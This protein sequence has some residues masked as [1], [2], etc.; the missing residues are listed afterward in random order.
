[1]GKRAILNGNFSQSYFTY[2]DHHFVVFVH[3]KKFYFDIQ[4]IISALDLK[5]SAW[6]EKY[7]QYSQNIKFCMWHKNEFGG[8]ILRELI[9][10][11]TVYE[12]VLSSNSDISKKF[13]K[14]VA[15][16]LTE[17]REEGELEI[18]NTEIKKKKKKEINMD[19]EKNNML[20]K[21]KQPKFMQYDNLEDQLR[22]Q[23][24]VNRGSSINVIDYINLPV[25]Y[26]FIMPFERDHNYVIVKIGYSAD[27]T[28]RINSL[29]SEFGSMFYL[30]GLKKITSEK[31]EKEFHELLKGYYPDNIEEME[32]K[33]KD[34]IELYKLSD[35]ILSEFENIREV[36][37][38]NDYEPTIEDYEITGN[39]KNQI[40]LFEQKL[41]NYE[42]K[43]LDSL[44]KNNPTEFMEMKKMYYQLL[45]AREQHNHELLMKQFDQNN[46]IAQK[47][48]K[49]EIIKL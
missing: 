45:I 29:Q 31:T 2:N 48:Q 22:L 23:Y 44:M 11:T 24:L 43:N 17:L 25:M 49:R 41:R 38:I 27:I 13:K 20:K 9:D 15:R 21:F 46:K 12:L 26:M 6:N 37:N 4:H 35:E 3:N 16:I 10:E 30:I 19:V 5:K 33:S 36:I 18:T 39:I 7:K 32:I 28:R 34:K 40:L 8:Y 47:K 42:E 14:N 1:L